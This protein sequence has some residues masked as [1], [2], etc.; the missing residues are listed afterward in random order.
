MISH[1]LDFSKKKDTISLTQTIKG[2]GWVEFVSESFSVSWLPEL[3]HH[4]Q[5]L[6]AYDIV[7]PLIDQDVKKLGLMSMLCHERL[8]RPFV[9]P[10][11]A[12]IDE[13][14]S[15]NIT[16]GRSRVVAEKLCG[17][18][19]MPVIVI[20]PKGICPGTEITTTQQFNDILD[21]ND[22]DYD[23]TLSFN[24]G[25][26]PC[27]ISSILMHSAYSDIRQ[28][29]IE[30]QGQ[31]CLS[32]WQRYM[33]SGPIRLKIYCQPGQ[34]NLIVTTR[35]L[36]DGRKLFDIEWMELDHNEFSFGRILHE[37]ETN[38]GPDLKLWVYNINKPL[39]LENL[40]P[41]G[42]REYAV[43][44]TQNRSLVMF[45]TH[46]KTMMNVIGNIVK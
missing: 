38:N 44:H 36:P 10:L 4:V 45:S 13:K 40:I 8:Q 43:S 42:H 18:D 6:M 35:K 32:F 33:T 1:L 26:T 41:W 46:A 2:Q 11:F 9:F 16:C 3:P 21:L 34:Q 24:P 23:M 20:A 17:S 25:E 7:Q 28:E 30:L 31:R 19:K 12:A 39:Y 5:A 14:G 15:W 22:I 37:F 29:A 27:V